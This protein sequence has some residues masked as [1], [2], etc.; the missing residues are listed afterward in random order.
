MLSDYESS[1]DQLL[2]L[3]GSWA[4]N[5]RLKRNLCIE[6]YKTLNDLNP[7]FMREIFETR[8]TKRAVRERYK[9]NLEIPR[10]NQAS[11]GT[12]SL[13]FYG[14]KIW[15]SLPYHIKSTENLLCFKNV[16]KSWNGPFCNCKVCRKYPS[17][18][19]NV[20]LTLFQRFGSTLK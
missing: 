20:G 19:F 6:I 14:P 16:I 7:S 18:H 13:R 12:K 8:K 11:F 5:V 9:I 4:T 10:V 15:N 1:Y 3:S 2:S 17:Q